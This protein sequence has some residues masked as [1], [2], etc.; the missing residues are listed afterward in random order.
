MPWG[1]FSEVNAS[2]MARQRQQEMF[3]RARN[4]ARAAT[5]HQS[6]QQQQLEDARRFHSQEQNARSRPDTT[7]NDGS[8]A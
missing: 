2:T 5:A 3:D 1:G 6:A 4:M 7:G 8:G